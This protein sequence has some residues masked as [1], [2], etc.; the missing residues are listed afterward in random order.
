MVFSCRGY[1]P[2]EKIAAAHD[3]YKAAGPRAD[4]QPGRRLLSTPCTEAA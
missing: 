1:C 3:G 4:R 2:R